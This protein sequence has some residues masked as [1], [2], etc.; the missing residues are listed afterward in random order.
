ME[1]E[2]LLHQAIL[3]NAEYNT[4]FRVVHPDR[5]IHFIKAYGIVVRDDQGTSLQHDGSQ[6]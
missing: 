6:F 4:E 5:S 3:G 2:T 1:T